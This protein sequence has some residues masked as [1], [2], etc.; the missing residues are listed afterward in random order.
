MYLEAGER[1]FRHK[2]LGYSEDLT[3]F[4]KIFFAKIT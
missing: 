1:K 3:N 4:L 2:A